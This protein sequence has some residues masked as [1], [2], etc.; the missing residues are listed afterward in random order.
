MI[1]MSNIGRDKEATMSKLFHAPLQSPS[2]TRRR[3]DANRPN[4]FNLWCGTSVCG[5]VTGPVIGG[6]IKPLHDLIAGLRDARKSGQE[7]QTS[8]RAAGRR[9][10]L[11]GVGVNVECP[12]RFLFGRRLFRRG[13]AKVGDYVRL[14]EQPS[15]LLG[16]ES[17]IRFTGRAA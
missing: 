9:P 11:G 1:K 12:V 8:G 4:L 16:I 10:L 13:R 6:E 15:S 2:V 17:R 14:Q 3:T 5:M 7:P